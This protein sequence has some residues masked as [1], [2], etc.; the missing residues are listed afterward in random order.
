V[1]PL[2]NER[3]SIEIWWNPK[4]YALQ[5][6]CKPVE[7]QWNPK[8]YLLHGGRK[9]IEM[10][11]NAVRFSIPIQLVFDKFWHVY[12]PICGGFIFWHVLTRGRVPTFSDTCFFWH[13]LTRISLTSAAECTASE[14]SVNK[15]FFD[16]FWHEF[17]HVCSLVLWSQ[18][19]ESESVEIFW[20]V[21]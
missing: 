13:V 6:R 4:G 21:F 15:Y 11:P 17:M 8:G 16:T 9:Y 12:L 7:V 10:Q 18:K 1:Y 19:G 20:H 3:R 2:Q 5:N 14:I